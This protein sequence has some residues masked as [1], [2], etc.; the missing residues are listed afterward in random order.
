MSLTITPVSRDQYADASKDKVIFMQTP[1]WGDMRALSGFRPD[2]YLVQENDQLIGALLALVKI[3]RF[4]GLRFSAAYLPRPLF[5]FDE[6]RTDGIATILQQLKSRY[7]LTIV[8]YNYPHWI[9]ERPDEHQ[10]HRAVAEAARTAGFIPSL[11]RVQ[12]AAT[13]IKTISSKGDV[14]A[15]LASKYARRDTRR[16]FQKAKEL[17]IT[18]DKTDKLSDSQL[19]RVEELMQRTAEAKGFRTRKAPYLRNFQTYVSGARWF[20]ATYKGKLLA[21][22]LCVRDPYTNTDY[23]L[24]IGYRN[25]FDQEVYLTYATRAFILETLQAEGVAYYDQWGISEDPASP[26]FKLSETKKRFGGDI[27]NYPLTLVGSPLPGI[28]QLLRNRWR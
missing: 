19:L 22:T 27:I 6:Q 7:S 20:T 12:P 3:R 23:S 28:A 16:G 24:Y 21:A 14:L 5:F 10:W 26:L 9:I 8:E 18:Y 2:Y 1:G 17:G 25:P 11:Q 15:T 4:G 13:I